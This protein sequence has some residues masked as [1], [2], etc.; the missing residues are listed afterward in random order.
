MK[1]IPTDVFQRRDFHRWGQELLTVG[2]DFRDRRS[3][4][5]QDYRIAPVI[6]RAVAIAFPSNLAWSGGTSDQRR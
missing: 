3:R 2:E 4:R 6:R 5:A 1:R